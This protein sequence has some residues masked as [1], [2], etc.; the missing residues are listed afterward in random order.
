MTECRAA[1]LRWAAPALLLMVALVLITHGFGEPGVREV[2]R[3]TGRT[4]LLFFCLAFASWGLGSSTWPT[5]NRPGLLAALAVSHFLHLLAI[6]ALAWHTHGVNLAERASRLAGGVLAYAAIF[7]AA[8]RP[9]GAWSRWGSF[10]VWIVFLA[11]YAPRA[12]SDPRR[13]APPVALLVA[14]LLVR[15]WGEWRRP[16]AATVHD[17]RQRLAG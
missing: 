2:V 12:I 5:R 1:N 9:A 13:F 8:W 10:W 14:V 6:F 15:L 3:W 11:S 16:R 7:L 17:G 4:S